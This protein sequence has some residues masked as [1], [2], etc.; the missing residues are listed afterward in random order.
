MMN[1]YATAVLDF[2]FTVK[3]ANV[4]FFDTFGS[5][6]Q[7]S[8]F[9]FIH[10]EDLPKLQEIVDSLHETKEA[11]HVVRIKDHNGEYLLIL[12]KMR[13]V[14]MNGEEYIE[15][16]FV[17][18]LQNEK[19]YCEAEEQLLLT[20]QHLMNMEMMCFEYS[21]SSKNFRIFA[22]SLNQTI[23]IYNGNFLD[24]KYS[25]LE[26]STIPEDQHEVF[27]AFCFDLESGKETFMYK[28]KSGV[29]TRGESIEENIVRCSTITTALGN[30]FVIG[31]VSSIVNNSTLGV[32]S[33][34]VRTYK[35]PMTG[36][37]NKASV[38]RYV[39]NRL[40]NLLPS[41]SIVIG[42]LDLDN[43]K[44]VNDT[45]G[46]LYGDKIII[47]FAN[48]I[49]KAIGNRG[50]I[51]RFGGDEF[52]IMLEGIKDEMDLRSVL[53]AIRTSVE[54]E[55]KD[56]G[57]G[58][59]LTT[60]I[61]AATFPKDAKTYDELFTKADYCLYLSK[62]RGK[63][64]YVMFDYMIKE[65]HYIE[66]K[67]MLKKDHTSVDHTTYTLHVLD[68]LLKT[69]KPQVFDV[70]AAVGERFQ[71]DRVRV[72]LGSDLELKY[73]WGE[74]SDEEDFT[75]AY[76]D[77]YL[78]AFNENNKFFVINYATNIE[79]AYPSVY[80]FF[81]R[82][83]TQSAVQYLI[84]NKQH[85]EGIVSFELTSRTNHWPDDAI[86]DFTLVGYLLEACVFE[87]M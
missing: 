29:F 28:I 85:V 86:F 87:K 19:N 18:I 21:P 12:L 64:R 57:D 15:T 4:E 79:A 2:L 84:G 71:L 70:L 58:I 65:H 14:H 26:G 32:E 20:R 43:F 82:S 66:D 16:F 23:S 3:T 10:E 8:F 75:V 74:P 77:F 25:S 38:V 37:L 40:S 59:S 39:K 24:W 56:I 13:L 45:F 81:I 22:Y 42:I 69:S 72:F 80:G 60:S 33:T 35:D 52:M 48:I 51:G 47:Q 50:I 54:V 30:T 55:F 67:L 46:H 78:D 73:N 7:R 9:A 31:T 83:R 44:T 36:V 49:S 53:R 62:M 27:N 61:G 6:I 68:M 63:N 1:S 17:D 41:E 76:D 11:N 34:Y 5:K